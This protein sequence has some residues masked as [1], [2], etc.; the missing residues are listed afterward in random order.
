MKNQ[1]KYGENHFEIIFQQKWSYVRS[2]WEF[3]RGLLSIMLRNHKVVEIIA[4]AVVELAE[5]AVKYSS[6]DTTEP[7]KISLDVDKENK[8]VIIETFNIADDEHVEILQSELNRVTQKRDAR[9][10]YLEKLREVAV[11]VDGK[12]QLGLIRIIYESK[13]ELKMKLEDKN[14]VFLIATF[15]LNKLK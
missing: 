4:V 10:I 15:D 1:I 6:N 3:I 2:I 11:R 7:V 13:A 9:E 12:S 14:K 5:N 8:K